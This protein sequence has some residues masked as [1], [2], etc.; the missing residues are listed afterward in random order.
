[1]TPP[2]PPPQ[3]P[4]SAGGPEGP[5]PAR[6]ET[7]LLGELRERI[8]E[9]QAAAERIAAEAV[10][11]AT[12]RARAGGA[13][14]P[15]HPPPSGYAV[16]GEHTNP[17]GDTSELGALVAL[18]EIARS[19]VPPELARQLA[20]LLRELALLARALIDW[21][22]ERSEHRAARPV[23]VEDIPIA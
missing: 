19:L 18:I 20:E 2:E 14:T 22:L 7:E 5:D 16:P 1:M 12:A 10:E 3:P 13:D 11:A 9:T 17:D 21:Y 23:E 15:R 8:R 4:P 6:S